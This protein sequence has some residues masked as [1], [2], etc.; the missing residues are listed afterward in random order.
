ML[1]G[2]GICSVALSV[3]LQRDGRADAIAYRT[4]ILLLPIKK[5]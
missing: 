1:K 4:S 2:F 3:K 5:A